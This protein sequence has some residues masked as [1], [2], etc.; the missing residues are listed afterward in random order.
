MLPAHLHDALASVCLP[1]DPDLVLCTVSLSFHGLWGWLNP[2]TNTPTGSNHRGH[3]NFLLNLLLDG[4]L[5]LEDLLGGFLLQG[6]EL[7][8][9]IQGWFGLGHDGVMRIGR[10]GGNHFS[11]KADP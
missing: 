5:G 1:Q 2:K 4:G 6:C 10:L 9:D 11:E 7:Y 8:E 3:V